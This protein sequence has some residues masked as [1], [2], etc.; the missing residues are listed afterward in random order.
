[1]SE[2][3]PYCLF[4]R[5]RM[6]A[7][8]SEGEVGVGFREEHQHQLCL[9]SLCVNLQGPGGPFRLYLRIDSRCVSLQGA[10]GGLRL[11]LRI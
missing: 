7:C 1:M 10:R 4:A 9:D 8:L 11:Y 6:G 5:E 3:P 2:V